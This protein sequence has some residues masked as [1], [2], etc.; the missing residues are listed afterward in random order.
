LTSALLTLAST[1]NQTDYL[2]IGR[3]VDK[4]GLSGMNIDELNRFLAEG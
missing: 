3:T 4:L 2:A 1:I